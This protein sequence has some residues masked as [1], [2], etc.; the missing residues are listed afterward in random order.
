M[1]KRVISIFFWFVGIFIETLT[2]SLIR[3]AIPQKFWFIISGFTISLM[4]AFIA[5]KLWK[6]SFRYDKTK[7]SIKEKKRRFVLENL[8]IYASIACFVPIG[9]YFMLDKSIDEKTKN[10]IWLEMVMLT[11]WMAYIVRTV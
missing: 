11:F 10:S 2:L 8:Y 1:F 3:I 6:T 7:I 4:L 5:T 9:F